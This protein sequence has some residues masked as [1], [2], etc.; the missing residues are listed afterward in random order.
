MSE[1]HT[2]SMSPVCLR[3]K[4]DDLAVTLWPNPAFCLRFYHP[5]TSIKPSSWPTAPLI[6]RM[7]RRTSEQ[8]SCVQSV[9]SKATFKPRSSTGRQTSCFCASIVNQKALH[10]PSSGFHTGCHHSGLQGCR[11]PCPRRCDMSLDQKCS[12]ILDCTER[13]PPE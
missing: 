4:V 6:S 7:R 11:A 10:C 5:F 1:L 8:I 3:W 13:H 9:L 2:L 12:H